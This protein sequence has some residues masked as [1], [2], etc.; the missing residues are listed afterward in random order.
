MDIVI[1]FFIIGF[2]LCAGFLYIGILMY[3]RN[4]TLGEIFRF[5]FKKEEKTPD[6]PS[7]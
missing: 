7:H 2:L 4:Y 3:L 6:K 5:I 1:G